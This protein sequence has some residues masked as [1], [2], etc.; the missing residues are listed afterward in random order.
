M[1]LAY[2]GNS[3]GR[4]LQRKHNTRLMD[5]KLTVTL[6]WNESW[7]MTLCIIFMLMCTTH[8]LFTLRGKHKH[9]LY[10]ISA[11]HTAKHRLAQCFC[12]RLYKPIK[13]L[14]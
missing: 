8:Q 2:W 12:A 9:S 3:A 10:Y 7:S 5:R 1:D 6:P 14:F 13:K 11:C 4:R